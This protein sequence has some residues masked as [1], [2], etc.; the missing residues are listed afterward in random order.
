MVAIDESSALRLPR[1]TI[2][3][4][5]IRDD[6]QLFTKVSNEAEFLDDMAELEKRLQADKVSYR[7]FSTDVVIRGSKWSKDPKN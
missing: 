1:N 4:W 5:T 3:D 2:P 7:V 6:K